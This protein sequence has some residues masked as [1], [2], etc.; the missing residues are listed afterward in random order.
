M[1]LLRQNHASKGLFESR[2]C[3]ELLVDKGTFFNISAVR[4]APTSVGTES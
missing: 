1:Y 2:Q 3:L 4:N